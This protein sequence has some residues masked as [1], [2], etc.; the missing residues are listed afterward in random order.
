VLLDERDGRLGRRCPLTGVIGTEQT[1]DPIQ[2]YDVFLLN[3][4]LPFLW[5]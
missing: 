5:G 2:P 1:K 3:S 4:G